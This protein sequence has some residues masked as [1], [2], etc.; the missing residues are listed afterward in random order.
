MRAGNDKTTKNSL[1]IPT[2]RMT[3]CVKAIKVPEFID[4]KQFVNG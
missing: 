4:F 1:K 2:S 3:T